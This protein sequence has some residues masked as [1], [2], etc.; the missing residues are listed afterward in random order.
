MLDLALVMLSR[1]AQEVHWGTVHTI[2]L[3]GPI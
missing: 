3:S 1:V 2:R